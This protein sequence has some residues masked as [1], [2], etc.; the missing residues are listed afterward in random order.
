MQ[1]SLVFP[2]F[3]G[4]K[5]EKIYK[6]KDYFYDHPTALDDVGTIPALFNSMQVLEDRDFDVIAVAGANAPSKARAVERSAVKLLRKHARKAGVRLHFFSYSHLGRLHQYFEQLGRED[7][8]ETV[9]LVGYSPLRNAC[10]V[11][12]HILDK[13]VAVSIDDDCQFIEPNYIDRIKT[14]LGA[15]F[16]G[17][18]ILA[19]CGPYLTESGSIYLNRSQSPHVAYWNVIDAMN[20]TFRRYIVETPGLKETPIA[21]MGN[22]AV[23]REFFTR[24]PLDP[25]L[26]RGEDM[27]WVMNAHILGERFIMDPGLLIKHVPPPRPYPTWR[28]MREDIYRFRYQQ[29][30]IAN[31]KTGDGYHRLDRERYLPYPGIFYQDDFLDRVFKASTT[32]AIDYLTQGQK[33]AAREALDN[34]YHAHYLAEP[35][36]NPFQSYIDFQKKW[37]EMMAIISENRDEVQRLVFG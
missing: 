32:L 18:P 20:E 29:A 12:A 7:L 6:N 31:S 19:Y 14:H 26:Q 1:L 23:H 9:S 10:L 5:K 8:N 36:G 11:A 28:P 16:E 25:P 22:I 13:E 15:E 24:V 35:K 27:D 4:R 17:K 33:K 37:V 21:I 2:M 34:I 3:W 30:K